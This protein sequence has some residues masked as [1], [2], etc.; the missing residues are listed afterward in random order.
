MQSRL[1][2]NSLSVA[3]NAEKKKLLLGRKSQSKIIIELKDK[4]VKIKD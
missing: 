3:R 1:A 2:K 4:E